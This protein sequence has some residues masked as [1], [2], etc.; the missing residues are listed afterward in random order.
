MRRPAELA[1]WLDEIELLN[2]MRDAEGADECRKRLCVWLTH[3]GRFHAEEVAEMLGVSLPSVW[4]WV[5]LYNR[6]GPSALESVGRGGRRWAYLPVEAEE[7]LLDRFT[8]RALAGDLISAKQ[9]HAEVSRQVGKEVSLAYVYKLLH[10]RGWRKLG[11]RPRH[12]KADLQGQQ[13][14]KKT[15]QSLSQRS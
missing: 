11:P 9:L 7:A 15:S 14:F 5:S 4:R 8:T 10:R 13:A 12:V 1:P 6:R 3:F 2:W